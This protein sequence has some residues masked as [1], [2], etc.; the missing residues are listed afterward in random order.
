[1][2]NILVIGYGNVL[3]SDDGLGVHAAHALEESFRSRA[4]VRVIAAHQLTPEMAEDVSEARFVLF[5][6]CAV[7]ETPGEIVETLLAPWNGPAGISHHVTP[8]ALLEAAEQLYGEAPTAISL[9][10][11]GV[12]F[13]VGTRMSPTVQQRLP[14]LVTRARQV[15]EV[16]LGNG[17]LADSLRAT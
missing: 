6:D 14:E 1:M 12:W 15:I 5:L 16:W 8:G 2:A 11:S 10:V 13:D 7:G 4:E 9:T 3:R 17:V